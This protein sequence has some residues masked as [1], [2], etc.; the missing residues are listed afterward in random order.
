MK[1]SDFFTS[2][3]GKKLVM[4]LSGL[5]LISFLVVHVGLNACV[6]N[7]LPFF[8]PTDDGRMFN[9]AAH[10]MG[11]TVVIRIMEIGLF[12]FF[13]IHIIQGYVL[14][15][16]NR[17]KR[18]IGYKVKMGSRGSTWYSKSMGLL[19]TLL[20]FFLIMH[21]AH[22]WVPSRVTHDLTPVTYGD[23][24]AHNLFERM[25]DVFQNP[26]IVILYVLGCISL[27]WHLLHGF[28]SAFRTLG[29]YNHRYIDTFKALGTGFS[30]FVPLLF[31]L[32]PI[33]M[34]FGWVTYR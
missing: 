17:S 34:Y 32:M 12:V 28:Q 11:S 13:L 25:V 6:F 1:W 10:F 5:F 26:W 29:L 2:S 20:L 19:G 4:S 8:D 23:M 18:S 21:I 30:I 22:F 7:D 33:S 27:G 9:K 16:Q 3:V 14:E 24:E 31:A 15:V